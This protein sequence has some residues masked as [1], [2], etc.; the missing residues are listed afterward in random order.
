MLSAI[1][2]KIMVQ[3]LRRDLSLTCVFDS[4]EGR[5]W[6]KVKSLGKLLPALFDREFLFAKCLKELAKEVSSMWRK[7]ENT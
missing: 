5:I 2:V 3:A 1:L 7:H 6:F 4:E